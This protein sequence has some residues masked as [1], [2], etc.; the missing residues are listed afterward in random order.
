MNMN[1]NFQNLKSKCEND[2]FSSCKNSFNISYLLAHI[3]S[4]KKMLRVQFR[5]LQSAMFPVDWCIQ[6][7]FLFF[8]KE[9]YQPQFLYLAQSSH[10]FQARMV[11]FKVGRC[12]QA[13]A[14]G[15]AGLC[16]C[17]VLQCA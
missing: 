16:G 8:P 5:A 14:S 15:G 1:T 12:A 6:I 17:P 10:T 4:F 9:S 2:T 13:Q 3:F 11:L 7:V